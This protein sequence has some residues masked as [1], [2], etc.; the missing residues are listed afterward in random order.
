MTDEQLARLRAP[1]GLDLKANTPEET[2][3]SIVA[4]LVAV[5]R[6][7]TGMPLTHTHSPIHGALSVH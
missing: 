1:I 5:Q 6:G 3:L 4:E 7:G 2:A